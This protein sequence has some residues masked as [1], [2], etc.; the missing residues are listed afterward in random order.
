QS[1]IVISSELESKRIARY[2]GAAYCSDGNLKQWICHHCQ[3]LGSAVTIIDIFYHKDTKGRGFIAI[4]NHK[5]QIILSFRGSSNLKNWITNLNFRQTHYKVKDG[6]PKMKV[7]TGFKNAIDALFPLF[8]PRIEK[9]LIRY[10]DHA[11]IVTGHSLGGAL[12][13]LATIELQQHLNLP[14]GRIQLFTYGSPRVGNKAFALWLN[15]KYLSSTRVVFNRDIVPHLPPKILEYVHYQ[16]E[17][18]IYKNRAYVCSDEALEDEKCSLAR[19]PIL[20]INDHLTYWD[21]R[22]GGIC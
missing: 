2:A 6:D 4:D 17:L 5:S 15:S 7:H 22:L 13:N 16:R 10:P 8:S 18:H 3:V 9:L 11:L 20:S 1:N 21:V 19:A 12:A 14:W